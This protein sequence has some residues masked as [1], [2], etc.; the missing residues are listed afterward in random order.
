MSEQTCGTTHAPTTKAPVTDIKYHAKL[1]ALMA[2]A[3]ATEMT[4]GGGVILPGNGGPGK[5]GAAKSLS[6][7]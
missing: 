2:A 4:S 7:P 6:Q 3:G 1:R 5:P